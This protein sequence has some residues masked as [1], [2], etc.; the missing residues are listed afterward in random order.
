[1]ARLV[2]SA[3]LLLF[4]VSACSS[5]GSGKTVKDKAGRTCTIPSSGHDFTCDQAPQPV[6]GCSAGATAC[7]VQG[8]D[9]TT[10]PT[11]IGA[12][13]VCAACCTG[14]SSSSGPGDCSAIVCTTVD[15]CP[16]GSTQCN[17]GGCY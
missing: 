17:A 7:F 16:Y 1:M 10:T 12:A 3:L 5:D 11:H 15:D 4:V 14:N 8:L 6:G 2:G 9:D 13:A